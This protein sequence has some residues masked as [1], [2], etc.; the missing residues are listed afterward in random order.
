M[1][2]VGATSQSRDLPAGQVHSGTTS[3]ASRSLGSSRFSLW[4]RTKVGKASMCD[5]GDYIVFCYQ[6][7]H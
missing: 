3:L 2:V 5:V 4:Q 7:Y 1:T 6:L